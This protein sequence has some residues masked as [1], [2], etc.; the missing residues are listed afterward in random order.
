M[1]SWR[2][3]HFISQACIALIVLNIYSVPP[4]KLICNVKI[5]GMPWPDSPGQPPAMVELTLVNVTYHLHAIISQ[6]DTMKTW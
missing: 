4:V 6:A 3:H 2:N 1:P 5:L